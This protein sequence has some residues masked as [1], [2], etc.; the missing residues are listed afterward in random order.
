[1]EKLSS[2]FLDT[3]SRWQDIRDSRDK[4]IIIFNRLTTF[5]NSN[6]YRKN[7]YSIYKIYKLLNLSVF[8]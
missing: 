1:M 5:K 4:E 3:C 6:E 2:I 8:K 7:N